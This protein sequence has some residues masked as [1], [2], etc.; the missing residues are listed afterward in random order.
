MWFA[1]GFA[2]FSVHHEDTQNQAKKRTRNHAKIKGIEIGSTRRG[3][4]NLDQMKLLHIVAY[5]LLFV[6]GINWGLVGLLNYNLVES[7]LGATGL[8]NIVYI[9]VGAAAVYIIATHKNDCKVCGKK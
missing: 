4:R 8:V 6:G 2:S 9:L 3:V 7:V 5:T 1:F